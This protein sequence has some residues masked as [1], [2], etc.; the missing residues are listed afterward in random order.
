MA[1][2]PSPLKKKM[3][4]PAPVR[5]W[6]VGAF[7]VLVASVAA[8]RWVHPP[9]ARP[10]QLAGYI[11]SID[12]L[13][14]EYQRFY[15]KP[16]DSPDVEQQFNEATSLVRKGNWSGALARLETLSTKAALPLLFNNLGILYAEVND[17]SRSV[18]AFQNA[19]ARDINY[20]PVRANLKRLKS[21]TANSADPVTHEVEPNDSP[22]MAN[23]MAADIPIDGEISGDKNDVDCYR[24]TAPPPPRD[25]I[26]I[27]IT[28]RSQTLTPVLRAYND[29]SQLLDWGRDTR[30]P[31]ESI[32]EFISP[33]PNSI[34]YFE[35]S[36]RGRGAGAYTFRVK[37]S[38]A[39]DAFEPNDDILHAAR[40]VFGQR[41]EAN[42][43][44]ENDLDYYS[45]VSPRTGKVAIELQNSSATLIPALTT[46]EP[47]MRSS[48]FGPDVQTPGAGL[49]HSMAVEENKTYFIQVWPRA[50][51]SGN[52]SLTVR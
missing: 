36:G 46:F 48:A 21:F 47:D 8:W 50:K 32:T 4:R 15:R 26:A 17:R 2:K 35:I 31:G 37:T 30:K 12:T 44:D 11:D 6:W 7:V 5:L 14:Q 45:F 52:Y 29:A 18:N 10:V 16:I 49:R 34:A 13:K 41:I 51:S 1:P 24:F 39:F 9:A 3:T 43:M 19:L 23:V 27:E 20:E 28:N 22:T 40:L 33:E 25:L 38:K 42:I